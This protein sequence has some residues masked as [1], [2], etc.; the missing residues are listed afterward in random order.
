[1]MVVVRWG[2]AIGL[3]GVVALLPERLL[4]LAMTPHK[5]KISEPLGPRP[6]SGNTPVKKQGSP[7][8]R[9][10]PNKNKVLPKLDPSRAAHSAKDVMESRPPFSEPRKPVERPRGLGEP[11]YR[12]NNEDE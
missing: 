6:V 5:K 2:F 3:S 9:F 10:L 1:M 8:D 4:I 12:R 7:F 11:T